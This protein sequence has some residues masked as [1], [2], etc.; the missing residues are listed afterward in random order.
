M[1][2]YE[3]LT[4]TTYPSYGYMMSNP[5]ANATTVWESWFFSDN[6]FSHNHP[7]FGSAEVYLMQALGGIQPHPS[8]IGF[9]K[10]GGCC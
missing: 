7:M 8:A 5:D 2:A 3:A 10:V 9:D 6:T 1:Q 4:K